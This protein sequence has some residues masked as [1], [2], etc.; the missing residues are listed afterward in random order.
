M[1]D[2]SEAPYYRL[3]I[4]MLLHRRQV[5]YFPPLYYLALGSASGISSYILLNFRY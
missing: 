5:T 4:P 2:D 1:A 3:R